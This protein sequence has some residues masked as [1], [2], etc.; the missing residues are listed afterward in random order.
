MRLP[1][2][3]VAF[4]LAYCTMWIRFAYAQQQTEDTVKPEA[5]TKANRP[6]AREAIH[7]QAGSSSLVRDRPAKQN[8]RPGVEPGL[9]LEEAKTKAADLE[10]QIRPR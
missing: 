8:E 7:A 4:A 10:R 6:T 1:D 9:P 3:D 5:A 2:R